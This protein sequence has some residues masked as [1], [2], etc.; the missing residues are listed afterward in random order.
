MIKS[1][2]T[3]SQGHKMIKHD[4][5]MYA[6]VSEILQ[7]FTNFGHINPD[8]LANKARIGTEVHQAIADDINEDLPFLSSDCIGYFQSY[9]KWINKMKIS[10]L[11][12]EIRYFDDDKMY[13]GQIDGLIHMP[14]HM[15]LPS[16]VDFKTSVS[17]SKETWPMQAHLYA[18][19][20]V[21]NYGPINSTYLFVKLNKTGQ[22]PEVYQ[23]KFDG[24]I[25]AKCM[26]AIDNF[27][28]KQKGIVIN[29]N[30]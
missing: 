30:I 9:E 14:G 24:N 16:L 12:S 20:L 8:V 22:L 26:K 10:F 7:P 17:E 29:D 27:W 4:G 6:R 18:D 3:I 15:L 13:C 28:N 25:R 1:T 19:L 21:K 11:Q 2:G 23:Y 5:K